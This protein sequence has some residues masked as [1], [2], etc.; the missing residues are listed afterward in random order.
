MWRVVVVSIKFHWGKYNRMK[1]MLLW[2]YLKCHNS[3]QVAF[4]ST[5]SLVISSQA[6]YAKISFSVCFQRASAVIFFG[7]LVNLCPFR[8]IPRRGW[9]PWA[10]RPETFSWWQRHSWQWSCEGWSSYALWYRGLQELLE[11][12]IRTLFDPY[13]T[14]QKAF[15]CDNFR[16]RFFS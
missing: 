6:Q 4:I 15:C 16:D 11:G 7:C 2:R 10:K 9:W 1:T 14:Y 5:I 13:R 8:Q 12:P 3:N